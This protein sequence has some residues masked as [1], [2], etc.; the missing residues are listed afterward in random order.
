MNSRKLAFDFVI[1]LCFILLPIAARA[2]DASTRDQDVD[3]SADVRTA[4]GCLER[5]D[6]A[7]QYKLMQEDGSSWLIRS[8]KFKLSSH[9][10]NTVTVTGNVWHPELH[11]AKEKTKDAV[12]PNVPEHGTLTLTDLSTVSRSCKK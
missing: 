1:L 12:N 3:K 10:G 2:Q 4:T 6:K 5:G 11:G 7:G 8:D 9:V